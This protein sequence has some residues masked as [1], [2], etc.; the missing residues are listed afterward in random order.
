MCYGNDDKLV[1]SYMHDETKWEAAQHEVL[2]PASTSGARPSCKGDDLLLNK[3]KARVESV[4]K[5]C[6]EPR[7]LK[8]ADLDK[9]GT[10]AGAC[11]QLE[12]LRLVPVFVRATS[13]DSAGLD[14]LAKKGALPWSDPIDAD[15]LIAAM[16]APAR[17]RTPSPDQSQLSYRQASLFESDDPDDPGT[18]TRRARSGT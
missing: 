14:A 6:A 8:S 18:T 11:E 17:E 13:S 2:D 4:L 3:V 12:K 7:S 1:R 5:L 10:W 9:G 15:G 16:T